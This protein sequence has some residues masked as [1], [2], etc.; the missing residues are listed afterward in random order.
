M[1]VDTDFRKIQVNGNDPSVIGVHLLTL[2][3]SLSKYPGLS[4]G[5]QVS[6]S[7]TIDSLCVSTEFIAPEIKTIVTL[8][9]IE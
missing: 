7:V 5:V 6:F 1:F 4:N 8:Q 9:G 2:N 3:V